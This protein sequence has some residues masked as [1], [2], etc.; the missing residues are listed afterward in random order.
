MLGLS[1]YPLVIMLSTSAAMT[2]PISQLAAAAIDRPGVRTASMP[3]SPVANTTHNPPMPARS[4][5]NTSMNVENNHGARKDTARPVVVNKPNATP[6]L[7]S[8]VIRSISVRAE[9]CTGPMNRHSSRPHTQNA[10]AP[11]NASSVSATV[12]I[13]INE[14]TFTSLEPSLSSSRPPNTAPTA[15]MMLAP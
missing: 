5:S 14:P 8:A 15:A 13:A 4:L 1:E 6:S 9:A 7:P 10:A 12:I 3:T 2:Q 11:D